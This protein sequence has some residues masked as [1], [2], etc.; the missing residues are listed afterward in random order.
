MDLD[1]DIVFGIASA[2]GLISNLI[3]FVY[4]KTTF[5]CSISLYFILA[6]DAA[7]AGLMSFFTLV[8]NIYKIFASDHG[9]ISCTLIILG[10]I[11]NDL[12]LHI[13]VNNY[14][15]AIYLKAILHFSSS[16]IPF[17]FTE[18]Y[19]KAFQNIQ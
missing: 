10:I 16:T 4:I 7:L 13:F 19:M 14:I 15:K 5:K 11:F 18:G 17:L 3:S 1:F 9:A 12:H 8:G 2:L 6:L